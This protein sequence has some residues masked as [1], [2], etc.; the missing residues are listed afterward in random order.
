MEQE[1]CPLSFKK[2]RAAGFAGRLFAFK[3]CLP[4]D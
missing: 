1:N 3:K 2:I 4:T